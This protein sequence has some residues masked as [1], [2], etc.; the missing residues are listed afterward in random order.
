[1]PLATENALPGSEPAD[2][3]SR[4]DFLR[5]G[6]LGVVGL[7]VAEAPLPA[8]AAPSSRSCILVLMTGG[9]SQLDTFDP[10][11]DAP[12]EIRGPSHAIATALP[13]VLFSES[14]PRLA[15]RADR[16]AIVRS[17]HHGAAPVHEAGLQ[18]MQTG[19]LL[20]NGLAGP[21][22]GSAVA[23]ALGPRR[24]MRPYVVVGERL[25]RTG[26]SNQTGQGAG[27]L[28][29]E[30]DPLY[31]PG[32]DFAAPLEPEAVRR[33]YGES[34][35]GRRCLRARQLVEQG[36]RSVT[37]NLFDA[38]EGCAT[39][40]CHA[41]PSAP[42]TLYDYRDRLVPQFDQAMAALL[43]DL[44]QRGLLE[45]TLVIAAGEFGRTPRINDAGGR[46]HWPAAWSALLAGGGVQGGRVVGASDARGAEPADRP[47]HPA[48]LVSTIYDR[49]GVAPLSAPTTDG[50]PGEP[51]VSHAP[52][53]ELF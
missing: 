34:A 2:A 45:S 31:D 6:G 11:P 41:R 33:T 17:L 43:D 42:A 5:V 12:S 53:L 21:S 30:F 29:A 51:F 44:A 16:L 13:G 49:F 19:C 25:N 4:R 7:S 47:I 28:G 24:G 32:P 37:V 52:I 20:R 39:W 38:L 22:F 40:D 8:A 23:S 50:K 35:F 46:D 26:V 14:L 15:V 9:A 10:K 1:M 48:E 18:L 27:V 36:V 3:V